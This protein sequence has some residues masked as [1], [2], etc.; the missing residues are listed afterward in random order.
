MKK[1]EVL[2]A[3]LVVIGGIFMVGWI[4]GDNETCLPAGL[5][6]LYLFI[7]G[8]FLDHYFKNSA[9]HPFMRLRK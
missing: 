4:M 2:L 1:I 5:T 9:N 7:Q 8:I 3:I 6:M